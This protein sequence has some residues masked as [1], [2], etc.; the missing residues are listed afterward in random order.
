MLYTPVPANRP[1]DSNHYHTWQRCQL[2]PDWFQDHPLLCWERTRTYRFQVNWNRWFV[3][4]VLHEAF[5]HLTDSIGN[6]ETLH[7]PPVYQAYVSFDW[8]QE[9]ANR[10]LS[11]FSKVYLVRPVFH[12]YQPNE[13]P[14]CKG[15]LRKPI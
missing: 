10:F 14:S 4:Y 15:D 7:N 8:R 2:S 9:L 3:Q 6:H 5:G 11:F 1:V 12:S 13:H